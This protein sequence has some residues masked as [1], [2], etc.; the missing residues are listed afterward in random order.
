MS[1]RIFDR[2]ARALG[3]AL[4]LACGAHAAEVR[5]YDVPR[6]ARP[7]DVAPDPKPGGPVWYTAQGQGALGRLDPATGNV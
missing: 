2:I 4:A 6:G 5:T 3:L 1:S 7:H